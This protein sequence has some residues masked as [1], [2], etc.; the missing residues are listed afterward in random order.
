MSIA[1]EFDN[2]LRGFTNNAVIGGDFNIDPL[3]I[4]EKTVISEYLDSIIR[5][6]FI[7]KITLPTRLCD[8]RGSLIDNFLCKV[9]KGFFKNNIWN[10][11]I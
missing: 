7:P 10:H 9:S 1:E 2:Y 5:N 8:T 11:H 4:K 6:G 3:K